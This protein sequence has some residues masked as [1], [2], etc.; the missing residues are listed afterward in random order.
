[1]YQNAYPLDC[2][3]EVKPYVSDPVANNFYGHAVWK[4]ERN[5]NKIFIIFRT[6]LRCLRKLG[7]PNRIIKRTIKS[8]GS[9]TDSKQSLSPFTRS[10]SRNN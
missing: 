9:Q 2:L 6:R 4:N 8:R 7:D 5:T 3:R 1:M 10:C